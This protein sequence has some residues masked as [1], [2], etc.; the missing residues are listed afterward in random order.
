MKNHDTDSGGGYSPEEIR[1]H[2]EECP[3]CARKARELDQIVESLSTHRDVFCPAPEQLF[4]LV[5][6]GREPTG[7]LAE[8]LHACSDCRAEFLTYRSRAAETPMPGGIRAIFEYHLSSTKSEPRPDE[9]RTLRSRLLQYLSTLFTVPKTA[10]GAVAAALLIAF[11]LYPADEPSPVLGLSTVTWSQVEP[12]H[13]Y[14]HIPPAVGAEPIGRLPFAQGLRD[15]TPRVAILIYLLGFDGPVSQ[16]RI[17]SLYQALAPPAQL[18]RRFSFVTP[19]EMKESLG[20]MGHKPL[21]RKELLDLLRTKREISEALVVTVSQQGDRF[22]IKG[23]LVNVPAGN[24]VTTS[25]EQSI[26][27]SQLEARLKQ[28]AF[29]L[30]TKKDGDK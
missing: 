7:R 3:E 1:R 29:T 8:H 12:L 16:E 25:S 18:T 2:V 20:P 15:K 4:E 28:I 11:L 14:D 9:P 13:R 21:G 5:E 23:E 30:L 24:T 10:I 6:S 26:P 22:G 19:L 27:G 17:D